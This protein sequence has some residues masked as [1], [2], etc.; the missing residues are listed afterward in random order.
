MAQQTPGRIFFTGFISVT[1][2]IIGLTHVWSMSEN[3]YMVA[4]FW[5]EF[6]DP[7][8]IRATC[9]KYR[10]DKEP[11]YENF[12]VAENYRLATCFHYKVRK[13]IIEDKK[14]KRIPSEIFTFLEIGRKSSRAI[15]YFL[16]FSSHLLRMFP[17]GCCER[18]IFIVHKIVKKST[19]MFL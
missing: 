9:Q 12:P 15:I 18:S 8:R 4:K 16:K 17:K 6:I 3:G 14:F 10:V 7:Q 2:T 5:P 11:A 1:A 19:W 13:P